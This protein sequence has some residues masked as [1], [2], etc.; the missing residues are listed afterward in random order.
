MMTAT[1]KYSYKD[2]WNG[3]IYLLYATIFFTEKNKNNIPP[4]VSWDQIRQTDILKIKDKQKDIFNTTVT[5]LVKDWKEDF[6]K[7]YKNSKATNLLLNYELL[8]FENILYGPS[9]NGHLFSHREILITIESLSTI[10]NF[11]YDTKVNGVALKFDFIHS[12]NFLFQEKTQIPPEIYAEC[13]WLFVKWLETHLKGKKR[14]PKASDLT[15]QK[16]KD[17]TSIKAIATS[18]SIPKNPF[19][20][21]F[22]NGY[23]FN[24]FLALHKLTVSKKT[25]AADYGF[26]FHQLKINSLKAI[27][28]GLP[29]KTFIKFLSDNNYAELETSKL[30]YKNQLRKQATFIELSG[31]YKEGILRSQSISSDL[32][33]GVS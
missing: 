2:W 5:K 24:L 30:P 31:K 20:D 19:P 16:T 26:I 9:T 15:S 33:S 11:I 17:N 1:K 32:T 13:C 29:H 10:R 27:H 3:E 22:T 6:A 12:P 14:K 4:R 7:R 8:K 25:M 28:S 21:I 18:E 23:A